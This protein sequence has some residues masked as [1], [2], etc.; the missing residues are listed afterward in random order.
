MPEAASI[1]YWKKISKLS[2]V[3]FSHHLWSHVHCFCSRRERRGTW[4]LIQ[5]IGLKDDLCALV[6]SSLDYVTPLVWTFFF[7][8]I[9]RYTALLRVPEKENGKKRIIM[10]NNT[11][12]MKLSLKSNFASWCYYM[13]TDSF[14]SIFAFTCSSLG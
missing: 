4:H 2:R 3:S 5:D 1:W 10:D 14:C 11:H 9:Q 6:I 8:T 12:W 7:P 13:L